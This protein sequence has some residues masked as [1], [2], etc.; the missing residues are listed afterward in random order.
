[1]TT[2]VHVLIQGNKACT[3]EVTPEHGLDAAPAVLVKPG[4][5]TRVLVHGEQTVVVKE[6]GEFLS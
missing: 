1:M 6:H 5:F 3:V 4:Q 2:E